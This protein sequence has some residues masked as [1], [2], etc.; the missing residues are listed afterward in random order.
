M[1]KRADQLARLQAA[2]E[3]DGLDGVEEL[4]QT[5]VQL[6]VMRCANVVAVHVRR[7][8]VLMFLFW[9]AA[10]DTRVD[11]GEARSRERRSGEGAWEITALP[12]RSDSGVSSVCARVTRV[13]LDA[14]R[15]VN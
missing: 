6:R 11:P 13:R 12:E 8:H 2:C 10:Q 9:V 15:G 3:G 1:S 5:C 14:S 7:A 4:I